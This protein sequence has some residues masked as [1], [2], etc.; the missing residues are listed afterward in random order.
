MPE[1]T[2]VRIK[3]FPMIMIFENA[4]KLKKIALVKNV[5]VYFFFVILICSII[6]LSSEMG[7]RKHLD[8]YIYLI[9][10]MAWLIIL[11]YSDIAEKKIRTITYNEK[12]RT[13]VFSIFT[14]LKNENLIFNA[15]ELKLSYKIIPSKLGIRKRLIIEDGLIK[16]KITYPQ[17][18]ISLDDLDRI[19]EQIGTFANSG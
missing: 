16:L 8:I 17:T 15:N 2:S 13:F 5:I 18:G 3:N 9:L 11:A 14:N 10:G 1:N 19:N 4:E 7:N 12:E 6:A